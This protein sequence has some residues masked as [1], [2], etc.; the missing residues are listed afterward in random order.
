MPPRRFV[1][2]QALEGHSRG[3]PGSQQPTLAEFY[4]AQKKRQQGQVWVYRATL[5]NLPIPLVVITALWLDH[6]R[7]QQGKSRRAKVAAGPL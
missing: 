2:T 5:G 6:L 7:R 3:A 1:L 4:P